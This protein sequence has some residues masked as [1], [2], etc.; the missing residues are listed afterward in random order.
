[1]LEKNSHS[2][3]LAWALAL[4]GIKGPTNL[5]KDPAIQERVNS[6]KPTITR[7]QEIGKRSSKERQK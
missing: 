3:H 2:V 1:M 7:L 6:A 5:Y 4:E